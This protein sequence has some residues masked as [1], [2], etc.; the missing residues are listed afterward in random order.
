MSARRFLLPI[1]AVLAFRP[2]EGQWLPQ[3]ILAMDWQQLQARG[4]QLTKDQFWHPTAGGVLS[5]AVQISGCSAAFVSADGLVATNHHCGF[6]AIQQHSTVAKNYL[7]DGFV[8]HERSQELPAKG[9]TVAVVRR[10]EDVS[11]KVH[12]ARDKAANDLERA[13][14]TEQIVRQLIAEG[15]KE[16][17]TSCSVATFFEGRTYHLYFRTLLRDVRL[18]YAPP[19]AVGEFG[20]EEDNWEWPRHTGDFTFFR[21]YVGQDG[22]PA[23]HA[24]GN[25]PFKP[26]HF[27]KVG[28]D[29]VQEGDLVL[30]L[31]YPGR[32]ERYLSSVAVKER[33]GF[34]WPKRHELATRVLEVLEAAGKDDPAMALALSTRIKQLANVQKSA[35]GQVRGLARNAVVAKKLREEA[36]FTEWLASAPA[37]Q[38]QWGSV[39]D[40]LKDLDEMARR[41]QDRDLVLGEL[42]RQAPLLRALM[43]LADWADKNRDKAGAVPPPELAALLAGD[44]LARDFA[45]VESR[46]L[47]ILLEDAKSLQGV[48]K[49][50][51]CEQLAAGDLEA[52]VRAA[53]AAWLA[54]EQRVQWVKK[55]AAEVAASDDPALQLARGIARSRR[56]AQQ[57]QMSLAGRRLVIGPRWIEAQEAWRGKGFYPDAN[58]SLRVSLATVR[59][60]APRDG[61]V[62][63]PRTTVRGLLEKETGK[64]PF[65]NPPALLA[66]AGKREQSRFYDKKL[67]DVPVCFLADADTT[68]GNSGSPI[69]NGKGELVGLNFDRVFENVVGDYGWNA[70]RSRN[71]GVDMRFVGWVMSEVLPAP[72]L[73]QEMGAPEAGR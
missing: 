17:D 6:G 29:G 63:V 35:L 58:S 33:Q 46:V 13:L 61:A 42:N 57:Q 47:A 69:I 16:P 37:R 49:I 48:Q 27:L 72:T 2:D 30:V 25:V 44:G 18:V 15:E 67:G 8:A 51:G 24:P 21:A 50:E 11:A 59:G 52:A 20:G 4:L 19:R 56:L 5:A 65:A 39:L 34:F 10:I 66:A 38:Q 64:E 31:G 70:D 26:Q 14:R 71:I 41:T 60:Y 22:K 28:W 55:P 3:Q 62:Y 12:A 73:L 54:P 68:G 7:R 23:A 53:F 32:T 40:E 45:P 36:Q 9:M 1:L 43:D